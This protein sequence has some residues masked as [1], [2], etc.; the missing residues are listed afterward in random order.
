MISRN[1]NR[2]ES[3]KIHLH[4][5]DKKEETVFHEITKNSYFESKYRSHD[6]C[7]TLIFL[8]TFL[9]F[10][11]RKYPVRSLGIPSLENDIHIH[12]MYF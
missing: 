1:K 12:K 5:S 6:K 8:R 7:E 9:W 11:A 10:V 3:L 2:K 4:K